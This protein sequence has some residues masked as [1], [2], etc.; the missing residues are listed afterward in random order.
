MCEGEV[1]AQGDKLWMWPVLDARLLQICSFG[2]P[3]Q[4]ESGCPVMGG[5]LSLQ[6]GVLII[7][8]NTEL[9]C[10]TLRNVLSVVHLQKAHLQ[11]LGEM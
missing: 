8:P 10:Q 1:R 9:Y 2:I 7:P 3:K 4:K 11:G 5:S 6:K